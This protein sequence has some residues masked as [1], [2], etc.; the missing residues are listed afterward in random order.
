MNGPQVVAVG[1]AMAHNLLLLAGLPLLK[2][3][4]NAVNA[5]Y[6]NFYL[7]VRKSRLIFGWSNR[8]TPNKMKPTIKP[9]QQTTYHRDGSVSFWNVMTQQWER[10]SATHIPDAVLSTMSQTERERIAKTA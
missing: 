8:N 7:V 2:P 3:L 10:K 5:K 1:S 4:V 6:F 9:K